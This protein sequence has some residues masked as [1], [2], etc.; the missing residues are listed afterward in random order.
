MLHHGLL[1]FLLTLAPAGPQ[2]ADTAEPAAEAG[3]DAFEDGL[4]RLADLMERRRWEEAYDGLLALIDAHAGERW[5]LDRRAALEADLKRCA[6]WREHPEPKLADLLAAEVLMWNPTTGDL[7]LRADGAH[8]GDFTERA[9]AG[10][11]LFELPLELCSS[12]SVTLRGTAEALAGAQVY[13]LIDESETSYALC[14][15]HQA[16]GSP[17]YIRHELIE[18]SGGASVSLAAAAPAPVDP[19]ERTEV[20]VSVSERTLRLQVNRKTVLEGKRG[21]GGGFGRL[22][23]ALTLPSALESLELRGRAERGWFD[24]L[25]DAAVQEARD[26]FDRAWD[27]A[28]HLPAWLLAAEAS[29][30]GALPDPGPFPLPETFDLRTAGHPRTGEHLRQ[31]E[32]LFAKGR[33]EEALAY[34]RGLPEADIEP[35]ARAFIECLALSFAERP[36]EAFEAGR[37]LWTEQP[38]SLTARY[39]EALL[40]VGLKREAEALTLFQ[41]LTEEHPGAW[42]PWYATTSLLLL[43]NRPEEADETLHAGLEHARQTAQL[44]AFEERLVLLFKGPPWLRTFEQRAGHFVV[45]TDTDAETCRRVARECAAA[46][47]GYERLLGPAPLDAGAYIPVFLFS[48]VQ[49]YGAYAKD[50][51][52]ADAQ[53][54]AGLFDRRLQA[55]LVW[56]SPSRDTLLCTLRHEVLHQYLDARLGALPVWLNEGLAEY[57]EIAEE[58]RGLPRLGAPHPEHA[59]GLA[60]LTALPDLERL[61]RLTPATFYREADASY[62]AAWACVHFLRDSSLARRRLFEDLWERLERGEDNATA[63]DGA[64]GGLDWEAFRADFA[65]HVGEL[66]APR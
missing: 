49:S 3:V 26:A 20:R 60:A 32:E 8:L 50:A 28:L 1:V 11:T 46:Y 36:R 48:G 5:V 10:G 41:R 37:K 21:D 39:L 29:Q 19:A 51:L 22:A 61:I 24:G 17:T 54:T 23:F 40:L 57:Y 45:R 34:A 13:A 33:F 2:A 59:A 7:C 42:E 16:L 27:P 66:A 44:E 52:C 62:A 18:L 56:S 43:L 6:F 65:R 47:R 25:V 58:E 9:L 64:F 15:G 30:G 4:L 63:L 14:V 35:S 31:A 55:I 53:H 38:G 12:W